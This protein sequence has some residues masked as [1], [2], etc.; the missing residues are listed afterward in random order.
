LRVYRPMTVYLFLA[1][2]A[3]V[4][5]NLIGRYERDEG[6]P[7]VEVAAKIT[8]ALSVSLDYLADKTDERIDQSLLNKVLSIQSSYLKS[9]KS[10]SCTL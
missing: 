9:T 4:H 5:A 3:G 10:T 1:I 8:D 6:I 7:S 2:K